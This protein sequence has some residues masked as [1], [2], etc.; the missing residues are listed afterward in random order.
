MGFSQIKKK[1][2][3][4]RRF[5]RMVLAVAVPMMVQ[6]GITTFVGLL[7]NIM[8]GQTTPE[9]M[10]GVAIVNQ[11]LFV[12][13]L[14][15]FGGL[16]GA[17]IFTAQYFG[18]GDR[19]GV[20]DTFRFKIWLA[21]AITG[22][23]VTVFLLAGEP[24]IR[25]YLSNEADDPMRIEDTLRYGQDYLRVMLLGLPAFAAVQIY[26]STLRECSETMLPMKA[27]IVAVLV[28]LVFNWLL[29]F[30]KLFFPPMG[31]TG[32]AVAT[33]ISR[34]VEAAIVISWTHTHR[35]RC[36]WIEK[37]YRTLRVPAEK[38]RMIFAKGVP[39]L[40][41]EALWSVGQALLV[42]CYS[43]RGLDV[44]NGLNI[45]STISNL[46]MII[47]TTLGSSVAIIVG[48]LLGAGKLKEAKDTDTKM[49][50]FSILCSVGTGLVM[51]LV[52]PVFPQLYNTNEVARAAAVS[53]M[54]VSACCMPFHAFM[55]AAYF[56]LRSGG[57]TWITFLFDS[58]FVWAVSIP[59]A[60]ILSRFT[61]LSAPWMMALVSAGE[62]IKCAAGYIMVKRNTWIHN[63]VSG[64]AGIQKKEAN[65]T[66]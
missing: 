46:F 19:E 52:C 31:V 10:N 11:L 48:Q 58:G 66:V 54:R 28:N 39:L 40:A 32:A 56:T 20:R 6:N 22:V 24:L 43:V 60:L 45:S 61:D 35:E 25:L 2:F 42:Q 15:I 47:F 21:L 29:I 18:H 62:L 44:V 57:K 33:V 13:N 8:V 63:M 4:D 37:M 51:F 27:G 65:E 17:G 23:A 36:P 64:E 53:L 14:C 1:Y 5:Y 12:F 49:I 41:N 30:G 7:D 9:Q 55:N 16:S 34:F 26:T 59:I 38:V 50:V 3:G